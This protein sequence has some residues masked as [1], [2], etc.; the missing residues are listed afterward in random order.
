M[1]HDVKGGTSA[2]A[3][4]T[5][6]ITLAKAVDIYVNAPAMPPT[7]PINR[8]RMLGEVRE[9]IHVYVDGLSERYSG[10]GHCNGTR[11]SLNVVWHTAGSPLAR[12]G[13]RS[14]LFVSCKLHRH[15]YRCHDCLLALRTPGVLGRLLPQGFR[16]ALD[17]S[18]TA[19]R[20]QCS[21]DHDPSPD[22]RAIAHGV[23]NSKDPDRRTGKDP[24]STPD[25]RH[26]GTWP[27]WYG[28][29]GGGSHTTARF[30]RASGTT[31]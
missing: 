6:T 10:G 14:F 30:P 13:R 11:P 4:A 28:C 20:P 8:S 7:N 18:C 31:K 15:R 5:P 9:R 2:V 21:F 27:Q 12:I 29:L 25:H 16:A 23:R 1:P 26:V 22:H 17:C 19:G 24:W 3:M